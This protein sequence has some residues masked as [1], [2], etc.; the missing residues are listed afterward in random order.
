VALVGA[1]CSG[2]D[3]D[4]GPETTEGPEATT[5]TEAADSTTSTIDPTGAVN[6]QIQPGLADDGFVGARQD[7]TVDRCERVDDGWVASGEVTNSSGEDSDYR[8]YV[9]LNVD[10]TSTTRGLV[11]VD[12]AVA[13]GETQP[14]EV[15][16][17]VDEIWGLSCILRVERVATG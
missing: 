4:A 17:P 13:D 9:A 8:I 11:Q 2:G 16:V 1:A 10:D 6:V 15:V 7:V 3:S 14:W 12:A 5:T